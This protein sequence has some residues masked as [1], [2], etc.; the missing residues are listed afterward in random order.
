MEKSAPHLTAQEQDGTTRYL[1]GDLGELSIS[2]S[3]LSRAA[4]LM[5]PAKAGYMT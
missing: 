2:P 4:A 5:L 3:A 1:K